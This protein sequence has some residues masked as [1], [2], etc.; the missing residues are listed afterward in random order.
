[1]KELINIISITVLIYFFLINLSYIIL[2][3]ISYDGI[4][5]YKKKANLNNYLKIYQSKLT[6]PISLLVPAYNEEETIIKNINSFLSHF[7]YPEYEVIIIN[8]GS[9]D[10]T[11][12][13]ILD[14]FD[15]RLENFPYKKIL[16]TKTIKNIYVSNKDSRLKVIDKEN[17]GKA[18][19]LNAGINISKYPYFG[20]ID[21]DTILERDSYLKVM[22]PVIDNPNNVIATGGIVGVINGCKVNENEIEKIGYPQN[23][24][25][26][27]QVIEYLRAF[28]FGRYAWTRLNALPLI[29]GAFGLFKKDSVFKVK[30]YSS[31]K[32][33]KS[34]VGEDM[35]LI[36]RLHKYYLENKLNYQI[37]FVPDPLSWTQVPEDLK[38][39]R[40]QRA[41]WHRGLMETF[42]QNKTM[43]FNHKYGKIGLL[44]L[45]YYLF[46]EMLAPII[47][48]LGY[49]LLPYFYLT[50]QINL[51]VFTI[52]FI[53]AVVLG[54][55][56]SML[57]VFL[58]LLTFNR[59]KNIFD[60]GKLLMYAILENFGYRQLTMIFRLQGIWQYF[61]KHNHWGDMKRTKLWIL[62]GGN[63]DKKINFNLSAS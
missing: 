16:D 26:G 19:A 4:R 22:V 23:I 59:Y 38:T 37:I 24:L 41:R 29:S 32:T 25:A 17:G 5:K 43:I 21:A 2:F 8:D 1:M 63:H 49:I 46:F 27:F 35:D 11:L 3:L 14:N 42:S 34:T 44:A 12:S 31:D 50:G 52:F 53:V 9:K 56:V 10:N 15:C 55:F 48:L 58:E 45:P 13:K 28:L 62:C 6:P 57:A 40:N 33:M 36:I 30:G 61:R 51:H 18:D 47:E 60:L 54:V 20:S 7:N 39:L